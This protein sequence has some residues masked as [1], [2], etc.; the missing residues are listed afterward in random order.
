MLQITRVALQTRLL[1]PTIRR[2][3]E[4]EGSGEKEAKKSSPQKSGEDAENIICRNFLRT[5]KCRY[6]EDCKF[7]HVEAVGNKKLNPDG[8]INISLVLETLTMLM[9]PAA[10]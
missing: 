1:K 6:D 5:G 7:L 2:V 8:A 3:K 10:K 9:L 4:K